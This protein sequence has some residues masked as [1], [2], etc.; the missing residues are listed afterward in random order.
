MKRRATSQ[1][2]A[3]L[4]GVSRSAVS[5]VLNGRGEGNVSAESQAAI[6]AAAK[7]LNYSPNAVALSLRTQRSATIGVVVESMTA[8]ASVGQLLSGASG[9][10]A[11]TG[12][13][14][15]VGVSAA[16]ADVPFEK[17]RAAT[18]EERP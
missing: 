9:I 16:A 15:A 1:D 17:L 11:E 5:L 2:V 14:L 13:V 18:R 4:A 3:D 10:A 7:Q 12:Y 8:S 6:R